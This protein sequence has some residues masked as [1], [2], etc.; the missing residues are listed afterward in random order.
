[1][2]KEISKFWWRWLLVVTDGV[3]LF[4]LALMFLPETMLRFF[5][6][7]FYGVNEGSS[8]FGAFEADYLTFVYSVLGAV[9]IGWAVMMFLVLLGSFKRGEREGWYT[10][11][12]SL[13]V[14]FV[15]DSF[16]SVWNG[17]AINAAF[18]LVFYILYAIPLAA[19]YKQ[20]FVA[21]RE[22]VARPQTSVR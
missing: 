15:V 16:I 6:M 9:M 22:A 12:V 7:L 19:T 10:M 21:E 1:M 17:F 18:N 11:A 3:I 2:T 8:L 20:F 14:W 4:S 5:N 13:T